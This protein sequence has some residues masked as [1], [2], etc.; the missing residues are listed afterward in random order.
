MQLALDPAPARRTHG[1]RRVQQRI[2]LVAAV[3]VGAGAMSVPAQAGA[4]P[5]TPT[6]VKVVAATASS[7]TVAAARSAGATSY[8]LY[9]SRDRT[10]V[11]VAGLSRAQRSASSASPRATLGG[12]A[13]T[14]ATYYY[15]FAAVNR[16]GVR[17]SGILAAN[18]RPATP[19]SPIVHS[20]PAG[21]FLTWSSGAAAGFRIAQASNLAMTVG[22]KRY[23]ISSQARQFTPY[24][25]RPG[26]RYYFQVQA[27]NGASGSSYSAHAWAVVAP[28]EQNVRVLTYN[29]LA[30][31]TAGSV[32]GNGPL[33][34]WADRRAGVARLIRSTA[35]DLV[36]VQEGG[37]WVGSIQGRGGRRQ[38]DDLDAL[39]GS[40]Y[41]LASTE[42]PPSQPYYFRT[43]SYILYN[44]AT[45]RP[46]GTGGHWKIGDPAFMA[47][48]QVLA[49]RATGARLLFTSAH[50]SPVAGTSAGDAER[51]AETKSLISQ[52][53]AYAAAQ[54]VPVIYAGDFNS[55]QGRNHAFDGPGIAFRA[56]RG[57]DAL[58]VAQW[59]GGAQYN[60]SNQNLRTPPA[61]GLSIDHIYAPPGVALRSWRLL[62]ELTA[63][64]FVGTIPSDH[65][66]LV[67]DATF[68]Y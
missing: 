41:S 6:G 12:L 66:P 38:V 46:I 57:S 4:W 22:L 9:A 36:A 14:T 65:N 35:P 60:S 58:Q 34:T 32:E 42:V 2:A 52:A 17:Y 1:R 53:S 8:R 21:T 31:R 44:P 39:L 27:V 11:Y 68:P 47:A 23:A 67:V 49:N 45:Y 20:S 59:K 55:H 15:R 51:E 18:L 40:S 29:I 43:G 24:G 13:Y 26:T 54:H 7:F 63:G 61:T 16:S 30:G 25:L 37:D 19:T 48:Y 5:A 3:L 64:R 28:H 50:L 56:A 33:A 10:A 62:L